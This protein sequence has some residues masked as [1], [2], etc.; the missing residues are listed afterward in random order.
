MGKTRKEYG[1]ITAFRVPRPVRLALEEQ[2]KREGVSLTAII[3]RGVMKALE[4][5]TLTIPPDHVAITKAPAGGGGSGRAIEGYLLG[6]ESG[7]GNHTLHIGLLEWT[8]HTHDWYKR[9]HADP[10]GR[11]TLVANGGERC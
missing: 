6:H 5:P 7:N 3:M 11:V 9:V 10:Q 1:V 2:A 4:E 8:D